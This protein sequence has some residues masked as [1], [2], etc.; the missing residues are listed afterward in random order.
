MSHSQVTTVI[1]IGLT[2]HEHYVQFNPPAPFGVIYDALGKLVDLVSANGDRRILT[3]C[4]DKVYA[5]RG[6]V[7]LRRREGMSLE[8]DW[9]VEDEIIRLLLYSFGSLDKLRDAVW[10]FCPFVE[11]AEIIADIWGPTIFGVEVK[12]MSL[13]S[14]IPDLLARR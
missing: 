7:G 11:N 6:F 14:F 5:L 10:E 2:L 4:E 1:E 12:R 13:L 8:L 9:E 3:S